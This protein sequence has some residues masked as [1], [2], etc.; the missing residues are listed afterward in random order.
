[1]KGRYVSIATLALL[2]IPFVSLLNG[3]GLG[4]VPGDYQVI[5]S[6]DALTGTYTFLATTFIADTTSGHAPGSALI[7]SITFNGFGGIS[8]Q[9]DVNTN[10]LSATTHIAFS[11][12]G[13]YTFGADHRGTLTLVPISSSGIPLKFAF[14]AADFVSG[15]PQNLRLI[16]FDENLTGSTG[17]GVAKRAD[18]S[19]FLPATMNQ[20]FVFGLQG[21]TPC[22]TCN[23]SVYPF[24]PLSVVGRFTGSGLAIT[25]GQQDAAA[26]NI[27]YN[28]I[29]LSGNLTAPDASGRGSLTLTYTGTLYPAPPAHFL[30]YLVNSGELFLMSSDGHASTSLLTGDALAQSGVFSNASLSGAYITY[31]NGGFNGDGITLY[32]TVST[33]TAGRIAI[34][35]TGYLTVLADL[36]NGNGEIAA[37]DNSNPVP[38]TIE[39]SGRMSLG[40][41]LPV[42]YLA[43]NG[44]LFGSAQPGPG[45]GTNPALLTVEPQSGSAFSCTDL[46][47]SLSLGTLQSPLP[48]NDSSGYMTFTNPTANVILD[49]VQ[50]SI[51]TSDAASTLTCSADSLTPST[52]RLLFTGTSGTFAAFAISQGQ[53]YII[54][55]MTP[56]DTTPTIHIL[57]R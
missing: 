16:E 11:A 18:A 44:Y 45:A 54:V 14:S 29:G 33:N 5:P 24:G 7:G 31:S 40:A 53:R 38:Y 22:N 15:V 6:Q 25:S 41:G 51:L 8:G 26:V 37:E 36:N 20:T 49:Q 27:S 43:N 23:G 2:S 52:G 39:S 1:M 4:I 13:A 57:Q 28:G 46:S 55:D 17:S 34:T 47:G 48:T 21:E 35:S 10:T 32:P 3:C 50:G 42:F 19:A 30:Y 12:A 56:T 9:V